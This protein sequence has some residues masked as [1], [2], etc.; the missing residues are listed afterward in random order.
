MIAGDLILPFWFVPYL[1]RG[2]HAS[3]SF[4]FFAIEMTP[5]IASLVILATIPWLAPLVMLGLLV[6]WLK[7]VPGHIL[8]LDQWRQLK[9]MVHL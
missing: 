6:W 7:A 4:K 9:K 1:L 8:G 5:Y 2:Y 3:F